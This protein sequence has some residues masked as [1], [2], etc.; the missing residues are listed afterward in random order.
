MQVYL[1]TP[2]DRGNGYI[3]GNY[4]GEGNV[5]A[6]Q[7]LVT[8]DI[9]WT[10]PVPTE[11]YF[12]RENNG[13]EDVANFFKLIYAN[14]DFPKFKPREFVAEDD[15]VVVLGYWDAISKKT[16][17]PYSGHWVMLFTSEMEKFTNTGNIMILMEKLWTL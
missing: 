17:K 8:D 10:C 6:I 7:E 3:I 15:K 16:G 1:Y 11:I 13:K 2:G 14:K 5:S 9:K 12:M 4:F